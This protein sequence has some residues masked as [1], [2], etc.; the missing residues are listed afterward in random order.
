MKN[1]VNR[2][3][4]LLALVCVLGMYPPIPLR[5]QSTGG[6]EEFVRPLAG[7]KNVKTDYGALGDGK[8][9]D[10]AAIQRA[11]DD[12]RLHTQSN[13]PTGSPRRSAPGER[14]IPT[15]WAW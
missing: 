14:A 1:S 9:D 12:L 10:T 6:G 2:C 13:V 5:A 3:S 15:A 4:V 8:A 11:L 7:W